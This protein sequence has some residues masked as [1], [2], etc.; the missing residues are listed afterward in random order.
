MAYSATAIDAAE[1]LVAA[2]VAA[3]AAMLPGDAR[4]HAEMLDMA[5][6]QATRAAAAQTQ[7]ATATYA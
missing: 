6:N 2:N 1:V 3:L 7:Y 5:A 4:I